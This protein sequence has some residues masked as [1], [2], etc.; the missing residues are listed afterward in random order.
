MYQSTASS[1]KLTHPITYFVNEAQHLGAEDGTTPNVKYRI[2]RPRG[3]GIALGLEVVAPIATGAE[4][5][6]RYNQI[7]G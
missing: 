1:R 4:L 2:V 6:S 7:L 3:G 5:L